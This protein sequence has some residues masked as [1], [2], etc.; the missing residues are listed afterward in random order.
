MKKDFS[1]E[2]DHECAERYLSVKGLIWLIST[3]WGFAINGVEEIT[4]AN[5]RRLERRIMTQVAVLQ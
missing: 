4:R 1:R 5:N 3:N 2:T